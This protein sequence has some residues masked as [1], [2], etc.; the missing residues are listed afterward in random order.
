MKSTASYRINATTRRQEDPALQHSI[1]VNDTIDRFENE[2][3]LSKKLADGLESVS[4][5]NPQR[6]TFHPRYI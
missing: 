3:L 4:L 6:F 1:L 5:K 2:N